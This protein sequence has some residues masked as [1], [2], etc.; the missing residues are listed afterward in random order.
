MTFGSVEPA[1]AAVFN[2]LPTAS[3]NESFMFSATRSAWLGCVRRRFTSE[4][5]ADG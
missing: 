2:A 1:I 4:S 3:P 5:R